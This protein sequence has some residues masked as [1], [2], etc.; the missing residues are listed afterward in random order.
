MTHG[1]KPS[2]RIGRLRTLIAAGIVVAL[3]ACGNS[4]AFDPDRSVPADLTDEATAVDETILS[5]DSPSLASASYAGGIPFGNFSQPSSEFGTVFN[6]GQRNI[7]PQYLVRELGTIKSR[8]GKVILKLA[9]GDK[10]FKDASGN[11]SLTKW[12]ARV[13]LYRKVNFGS[14]INDGT[15]IGHFLVDEPQDPSNWN[16]NPISQKT[17]E[18]MAQ[19]SKS[20]WPNMPTIVRTVPDYLSKWNGSYRYL[21]AAWA[22]YVAFRWPNTKAFL[23]DNVAKAKSTG[24]AL[25]VGM[26]IL[27]GGRNRGRMTA[28]EVKDYGSTLLSSTYPCAF[29][30][31]KYDDAYMSGGVLDAMKYLRGKAQNRSLKSCKGG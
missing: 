20:I 27:K 9:N 11:F 22:Q 29:I 2:R 31:W 15:V 6:G 1:S 25:V 14:Y 3:A 18:E 12:K 5:L 24:V 16:G 28:S 30:N 26:N 7:H 8:G 19:Y 17:L 10:Y 23:D 13:D 21:D 4:D